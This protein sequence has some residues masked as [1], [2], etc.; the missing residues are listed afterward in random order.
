MLIEKI[1]EW[2]LSDKDNAEIAA[3]LARSF[4]ADFG[5]RSFFTQPH[6]LR[7]IVRHGPIIAHMALLLRSIQLG[8]RLLTIAGLAEVA[9]D[10]AH[11]GQGIAAHLLQVAIAEAK[12]S[13][14]EF[15]LL[16]GTA[17]LYAAAGFRNILNHKA[18]ITEPD[19]SLMML[20]LRDRLWPDTDPLDLKGPVF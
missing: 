5:G 2:Q 4:D 9:T 16:F 1:P 11:R 15:L 12:T 7:L 6:H 3:L 18:Q 17:R 14:A 19:T 20:P 10:P 13:P 8:D